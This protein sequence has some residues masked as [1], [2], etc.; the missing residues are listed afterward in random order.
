MYNSMGLPGDPVVENPPTSD[1]A[2]TLYNSIIFNFKKEENPDTCCIM[3]ETW[4]HSVSQFSYS[5]LSDSLQPHGLQHTS[6]PYPSPIPG[7][8]SNLC[9]SHQW[10]NPIISCSVIPFSSHLPSFPTSGSFPVNQFFSSGGQS[11]GA[12]TSA[13]V[14]SINIQNWFPLGWTSWISFQ[15]K[16]QKHQ[17]F[18][19]QLSSQSNSHIH[20]QLLEKPQPWL[21]RPLSE[22]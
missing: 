15:S 18:C 22:K 9:P 14:L 1:W 10:C 19:T 7:A 5:V 3:N 17:F 16:A 12:S 2:H 8:C 20:T 4:Q 6:L 13:S 11:T 21:D